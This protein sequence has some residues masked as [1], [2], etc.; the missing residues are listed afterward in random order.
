M[1]KP[2]VK[3]IAILVIT[4]LACTF[5]VDV[6]T[7]RPG[8]VQTLTL[9]EQE[10]VPGGAARVEI[11]MGGGTLNLSGGGANL[12]N[13]TIEYN[14]SDW[15]P[16]I[17]RTKNTV[18]IEQDID[19]IPIPD[20]GNEM[21]NRWN[22]QLGNTPMELDI[23]AGAYEGTINLSGVPLLGLDIDGGASSA[24]VRFDTP[25]PQ[26]MSTFN[27]N[28][29][30]SNVNLYGLSNANFSRMAFSG[31][32]GDYLLDFSGQSQQDAIVDVA[33]AVGKVSIQVPAG[34]AARVSVTGGLSDV[35][36]NGGWQGSDNT[37]TLTG[38][39]PNLTINVD[40][41]VGQLEL[42]SE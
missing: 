16:V 35:N 29:G 11:A 3:L 32:A 13:G 24:E 25:N 31:A 14:L 23:D 21:V 26:T 36:T 20:T 38:S 2:V 17:T 42:V 19:A 28:T 12:V 15:E 34:R 30:A 41:A 4:S 8:E 37:Y 7:S 40:M 18:R 10:P 5:N 27:F 1:L 39:G 22:L 33:G 9:A 6:P